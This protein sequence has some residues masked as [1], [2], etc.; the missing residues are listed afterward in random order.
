MEP[1]VQCDGLGGD[2]VAV[3]GAYAGGQVVV[4]AHPPQGTGYVFMLC[5]KM[6]GDLVC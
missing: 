5:E 1:V 3:R 6:E 2:P 4:P